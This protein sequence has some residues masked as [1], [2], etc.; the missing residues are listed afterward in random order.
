[1]IAAVADGYD[2]RRWA[3]SAVVVIGVHAALA[4]LTNRWHEPV[5]GDEGTEAIVVDLAPFAAP[6]GGKQERPRAGP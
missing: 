4:M 5:V 6:P 2:L 1:M 3:L